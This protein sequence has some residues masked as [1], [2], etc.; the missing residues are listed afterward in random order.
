MMILDTFITLGIIVGAAVYLY[1]KF[2]KAKNSGGCS[3]GGDCCGTGD[4]SS[5]THC[6]SSK[7]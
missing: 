2:A 7:H 4:H 5:G 1:R 3:S 6:C